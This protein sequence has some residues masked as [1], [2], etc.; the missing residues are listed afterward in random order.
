METFQLK[1]FRWGDFYWLGGNPIIT[2]A[3]I[4]SVTVNNPTVEL[5]ETTTLH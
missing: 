2:P 3:S 1:W 5:T 4:S